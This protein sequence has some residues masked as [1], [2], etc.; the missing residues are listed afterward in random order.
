MADLVPQE[1]FLES[2]RQA[3]PQCAHCGVRYHDD[4]KIGNI[5]ADS[6]GTWAAI[7][8]VCPACKK[9][10]IQL[11]TRGFVTIGQASVSGISPDLMLVYPPAHFRLPCPA[12][13]RA[14]DAL[15]ADDYTEACRVLPASAKASAALSR[16]CLQHILTTKAGTKSKELAQQIQEVVNGGAVPADI[17]EQLDAVRNIGNFAAH[18]Q[19]SKATGEILPVEPHEAEWNLEVLEELFEFYYVRP[20]RTA[21]RKAA[22][23]PKLAEAGKP[24]LP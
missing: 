16:R 4:P 22:L 13:V 12:Q 2:L 14:E 9:I 7:W 5:G 1:Q 10:I 3:S 15:L 18:V 6:A 24:T 21:A 8:R 23:N 20:A 11:T 19:K 17:A